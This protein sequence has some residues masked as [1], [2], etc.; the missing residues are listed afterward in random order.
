MDKCIY[1][2]LEITNTNRILLIN[3][4]KLCSPNCFYNKIN[5]LD[6]AKKLTKKL[7]NIKI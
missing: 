2:N 5:E 3:N 7:K 1:C 4:G 6:I